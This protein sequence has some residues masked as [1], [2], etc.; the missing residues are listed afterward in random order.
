V[1]KEPEFPN[2]A[3]SAADIGDWFAWCAG[4]FVFAALCAIAIRKLIP[5]FNPRAV[6]V[7]SAFSLGAIGTTVIGTWFDTFVWTWPVPLYVAFSSVMSI[8]LDRHAHGWRHQV[9][10][11]LALLLFTALCYGYY[12]LCMAVGYAMAWGFL[13]GFVPALPFGVFAN[14]I[15]NQKLRWLLDGLGFV[16]YF[17]ISALIPGFKDA[18]GE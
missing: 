4:I 11:R 2:D 12:R 7:M 17:W 13:V 3:P 1:P 18:W 10:A 9:V 16:V 15:A 5:R 6:F 14:R 8:G